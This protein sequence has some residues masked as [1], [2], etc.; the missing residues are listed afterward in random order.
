VAV[1]LARH[2][3]A[4]VIAAASPAKHAGVRADGAD[5]VLDSRDPDLAAR[6]RELTGGAGADL[7]LESAGGATFGTSLA[8]AR[9]VTGRVV[10]LG[11]AGGDAAVS[12]HELVYEHPVHVVG[13][14]IGV[15]IAT[16]PRVFGEVMGEVFALVGA[17]VLGPGQP[18]S[19]DLADGP[20]ALAEL[21]ARRT[22]GKL[23]LRP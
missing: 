3:G 18:T 1:A 19:F 23:A 13:F 7:V 2:Y 22:V 10:V 9:P 11:A 20:K 8:A 16:A 6:V 5:H 12:N 15:L 14:N 17:G 21:A 4:T